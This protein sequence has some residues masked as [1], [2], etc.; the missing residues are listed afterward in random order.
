MNTAQRR[1]HGILGLVGSAASNGRAASAAAIAQLRGQRARKEFFRVLRAEQSKTLRPRLLRRCWAHRSPN[2]HQRAP[3][4]PAPHHTRAHTSIGGWGLA[5]TAL[6]A[7][8][9]GR[10]PGVCARGTLGGKHSLCFQRPAL[11]LGRGVNA[12]RGRQG[13]AHR[14]GCGCGRT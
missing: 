2:P 7:G 13:T 8:G 6:R 12:R 3:H 5:P 11:M 1:F 14:V 10:G 4:G 9:A